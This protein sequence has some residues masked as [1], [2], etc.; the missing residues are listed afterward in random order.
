MPEKVYIF[1]TTLRDGEQAPGASLTSVEKLMVAKQLAKLGVDI[2]EAGFPISSPDDFAAVKTIAEKVKGPIIC[3]LARAK[4]IDVDRAGQAVKPAQR[5]RI[6][7]FIA[8]S[9]IHLQKKLKI[10]PEQAIEMAVRAVKRAKNYTDDV[11]F[12]PED[13]ARTSLEYMCQIIKAAI[14]AGATT[15]NIPDTVGCANPWSFGER[16]KYVTQHVPNIKQAVISVHCHNDK[17]L[18]VANS[19]AGILT[20]A[21]QVECTINGLGERAGNASLEEIVM[22]LQYEKNNWGFDTAINT[23]EIYRTSKLVSGLT[24]IPVQRNKAIVGENAFA[25]EAGIHQHGVLQAKSTY[26][27]FDPAAVGW[28]GTSMIIGKHSGK[29]ALKAK[30][31]ELGYNLQEQRL[32]HIMRLVKKLADQQKYVYDDDLIRLMETEYRLYRELYLVEKIKA[33]S[34]THQPPEAH[35]ELRKNHKHLAG[36]AQGDGPVDATFKAIR[37]ITGLATQLIAYQIN[38]VSLGSDAKGEVTITLK[39]HGQMANGKGASTDIVVASAKA[40]INALNRL[41]IG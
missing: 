40:Y 36:A 3:G 25:H 17:G 11:E 23:K 16:I 1:D 6:H 2:I 4:D 18:A 33:T 10:T 9:D 13:A 39:H 15:I 31:Q 32:N 41:M 35:I 28:I 5:K 8:T 24:G 37:K 7:T 30:L 22:N 19:L 14:E 29:H 26:E 27:I 34:S 21:R 38:A 12:S 20:G